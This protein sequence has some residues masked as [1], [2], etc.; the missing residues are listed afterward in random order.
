MDNKTE[1][2][3][4]D[5]ETAGNTVNKWDELSQAEAFSNAET[6][7]L[8]ESRLNSIAQTARMK[9]SA[10]EDDYYRYIRGT[11]KREGLQYE[12]LLSAVRKKNKEQ[13]FGDQKDNIKFYHSTSLKGLENILESGELLSRAEREK[14]GEDISDLSWS[15]SR[16][17]QFSNDVFDKSG[18]MTLSGLG[19]GRG[20]IGSD[21]SFVFG[22]DLIDELSFD[23]S[24]RF[25]TAEKVDLAEKCLG[26]IVNEQS[27]VEE[28]RK[29][30]KDKDINIPVYVMDEYDPTREPRELRIEK[31]RQDV[32]K[33]VNKVTESDKSFSEVEE[34]S[35]EMKESDSVPEMMTENEVRNIIGMI[36]ATQPNIDRIA[37]MSSGSHSAEQASA[38]LKI[39]SQKMF[40]QSGAFLSVL[41]EEPIEGKID[42]NQSVYIQDMGVEYGHLLQ[43]IQDLRSKIQTLPNNVKGPMTF[44]IQQI[45]NNFSLI[46]QI[47]ARRHDKSNQNTKL[48]LSN[49]KQVSD[50]AEAWQTIDW[51]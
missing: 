1:K 51:N 14:R 6:P 50:E 44:D 35:K 12:D 36:D 10:T 42:L 25:P 43:A 31:A 28:V 15:S 7:L 20:A 2:Q 22:G 37:Y 30:L 11:A 16:D 32:M 40:E 17:I 46:N 49:E 41:Q 8:G 29:M 5:L 34:S 27:K 24:M 23:A 3:S 48:V 38:I 4:S 45:E 47:V 26:I 9:A 19:Q 39:M 18:K 33:T 21:I 13:R